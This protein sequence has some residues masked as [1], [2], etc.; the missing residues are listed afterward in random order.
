[1]RRGQRDERGSAAVELVLVTP[2]LIALM[3]FVVGV[4]RLAGANGEVQAASRDAAR[5]SALARS[6]HAARV[7]GLNAASATLQDRGVECRKLSV[8]IDANE[9]RADG[10]VSATVS[11]T[12]D[13]GDLTTIGFPASKTLVASFTSPVD[14]YRGVDP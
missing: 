14:R 13:L 7:A 8:T 5:A 3:L 9:F 11:C 6:P 12:V 2:V 1:M 4:G 10:F